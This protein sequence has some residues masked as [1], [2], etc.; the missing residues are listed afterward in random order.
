MLV[1]EGT[2]SPAEAENTW[3]N[4]GH[5]PQVTITRLKSK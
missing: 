4:F 1:F 3:K 5:P 2:I